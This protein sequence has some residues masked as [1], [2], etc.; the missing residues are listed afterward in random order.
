[1]SKEETETGWLVE[2]KLNGR[3]VWWTGT[4]FSNDSIDG[5]RF[6]REQDAQQAIDHLIPAS[7]RDGCKATDHQW[8]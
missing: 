1:M 5:I 3:P 2:T 7:M 8:G 4:F 6:A